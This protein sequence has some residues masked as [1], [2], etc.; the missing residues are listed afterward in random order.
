MLNPF[1]DID[2]NP[3]KAAQSPRIAEKAL[4]FYNIHTSESLK[5]VVFWAGNYV[6]DSLTAINKLFRDHRTGDVHAIDIKLI[7]LLY[8]LQ[9][10]LEVSAPFHLISGFR[11]LKSNAM[12]CEKTTGVARKSQHTLGRAADIALPGNR[13]LQDIQ[14]AAKML[15]RGGVGAYNQFVHVDVGRVRSW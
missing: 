6:S 10:T 8:A 5:N 9:K 4:S 15:G 2:Q 14:K 7:E 3:Q 12:L 13:S 1:S 11:S